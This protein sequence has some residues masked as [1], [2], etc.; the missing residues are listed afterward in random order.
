M[1]KPKAEREE[2]Y[3]CGRKV[4]PRLANTGYCSVKCAKRQVLDD[5]ASAAL[6]RGLTQSEVA[7]KIYGVPE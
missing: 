1:S 2:C 7:S 6:E 5:E 4:P 3:Q